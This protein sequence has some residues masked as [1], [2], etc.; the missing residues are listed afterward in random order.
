MI[1]FMKRKILKLQAPVAYRLMVAMRC[2]MAI[3]IGFLIANLCIPLLGYVVPLL[4]SET[5]FAIA[6][7]QGF[8]LSFVVWLVY[9][10]YVFSAK[11]LAAVF[12]LSLLIVLLQGSC[13][14]A[15]K[16]WGQV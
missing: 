9:I 5:T 7:A 2:C 16:F 4:F 11:S 12:W 8:L 10:I 1:G 6:T 15:A 14:A 3:L 13:I